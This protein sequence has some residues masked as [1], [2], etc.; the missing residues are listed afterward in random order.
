[1]SSGHPRESLPRQPLK[2]LVRG[3]E[4]RI[5]EVSVS[6]VGRGAHG[7]SLRGTACLSNRGLGGRDTLCVVASRESV[8][9]LLRQ[10]LLGEPTLVW[11][12]LFGSAA[13]GGAFRDVD[14]AVMPGEAGLTRL[15]ELGGLQT[16]LSRA[17]SADV[18]LVDLRRAPLVLLKSILTDRRLLLDRDTPQ[19]HA[20]E[21]EALSRSLDFEPVQ[22]R[23]L[24]LR[25]ER[26]RQRLAAGR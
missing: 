14:V 26:L 23:Q 8:E 4:R 1:M 24:A 13:R 9:Q 22:R 21:V 15:A 17:A 6:V 5:T 18:D 16:R 12:Y 7:K 2:L 11:A 10:A 25:E 3:F 20:W 19:R